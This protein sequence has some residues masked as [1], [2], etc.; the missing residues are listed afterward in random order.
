MVTMEGIWDSESQNDPDFRL[1]LAPD[2]YHIPNAGEWQQLFASFG[3]TNG[4]I[5]GNKMKEIG[6]QHCNANNTGGNNNVAVG[7][8]SGNVNTSGG[9]NTFIGHGA[10]GT[11]ASLTNS[12][13]IGYLASVTGSNQIR[14]GNTSVTSIG[15][16]KAWSNLSDRR[17]KKNIELLDAGLNFIN[18]LK[19]VTFDW[20]IRNG[21]KKDIS[22]VGFIAQDLLEAQINSGI[23]I[24]GL[25]NNE[26]LEQLFMTSSCIIPVL[27]KAV[28]EMSSTITRL[29]AEINELKM[30]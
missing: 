25:V 24:P 5:V 12:T 23:Q 18:L 15:G 27:V 7:F 11:V 6:F 16:Y 21:G 20:N 10:D 13:A 3:T 28:Q 8:Q 9:N 1:S 17:D 26:N 22:E 29:E 30:K 4:V 14:I 2:G 19:P